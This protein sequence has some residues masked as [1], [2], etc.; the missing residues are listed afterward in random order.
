[1]LEYVSSKK[2]PVILSTGASN[3][4]EVKTAMSAIQRHTDEVVLMQCNTNYTANDK[5]NFK[6]INLNV[7]K[8]YQELFPNTIL[9]LSDHTTGEETVLGSVVLGARVIE[10]H[11]TLNNDLIGPDHKFSMNPKSWENMVKKTRSIEKSLGDGLKKVEENEKETVILQRRA[12]RAKTKILKGDKINFENIESLRPC[13]K[14]AIDPSKIKKVIGKK[15]KK[16]ISNG[17]IIKWDDLE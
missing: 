11:F 10:K 2:K 15:T 17:E 9:G 16:N 8:K 4:S 3:I 6:H 5:D 14:E 13:P 1:M 12:I 7:L